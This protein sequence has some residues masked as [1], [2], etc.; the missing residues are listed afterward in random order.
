MFYDLSAKKF[1]KIKKCF[2]NFYLINPNFVEPLQKSFK[3]L[4]WLF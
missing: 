2:M 4:M 1:I 3:F